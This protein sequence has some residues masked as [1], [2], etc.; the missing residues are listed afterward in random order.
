MTEET[1]PATSDQ[2]T[3]RI[4]DG[5]GAVA[6]TFPH[7]TI[8]HYRIEDSASKIAFAE[9]EITLAGAFHLAIL[10][11]G[12]GIEISLARPGL[13]ERTMFKGVLEYIETSSGEGGSTR[14]V[15]QAR[16]AAA[17]LMDA[18]FKG[19]VGPT[20]AAVVTRLAEDAGLV[21]ATT[22]PETALSGWVNAQS[23]YGV[24]RL[25]AASLGA[26]VRTKDRRVEFVSAEAYLERANA[27][28]TVRLTTDQ[29]RTSRT[30][31]GQPVKR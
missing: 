2:M 7:S 4:L 1:T 14:V 30:V 21:A 24:L 20:L 9:G 23:S 15:F 28:P 13:A 10:R 18:S 5:N 6:L 8:G 29:I 11:H 17:A 19:E 26:V 12:A 31:Q 16:G 25:L 3:L 22:Y 27:R